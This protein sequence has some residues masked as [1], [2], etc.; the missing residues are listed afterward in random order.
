MHFLCEMA[1]V[2]HEEAGEGVDRATEEGSKHSFIVTSVVARS[3]G[4]SCDMA[5]KTNKFYQK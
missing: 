4:D 5:M 2:N 3:L 1:F